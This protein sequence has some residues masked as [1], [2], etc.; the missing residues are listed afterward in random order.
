MEGQVVGFEIS[1]ALACVPS[2]CPSSTTKQLVR[3]ERG[4]CI[5]LGSLDTCSSPSQFYGY[6]VFRNRGICVDTSDENSPYSLELEQ[7]LDQFYNQMYP[8]HDDYQFILIRMN[9]R[10]QKARRKQDSGGVFR[11]PT[12]VPDTLLNP[13]RP[14][15]RSGN[16]FKCTNPLV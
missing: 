9:R 13:C 16:N 8:V 15:E 2:D 3:N 4:E 7:D 11:F 1:G 14:G 12:S 6:D 10:Y 5:A